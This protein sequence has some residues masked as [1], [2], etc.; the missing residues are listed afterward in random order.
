M[1][2]DRAPTLFARV[3]RALYP[4]APARYV[5]EQMGS[6]DDRLLRRLKSGANPVHPRVWEA[7]EG[8]ICGR[9]EELTDLLDQIREFSTR[10]TLAIPDDFVGP[11]GRV[12][13]EADAKQVK[14]ALEGVTWIKSL[15]A[16]VSG[17]VDFS[18]PTDLPEN[19]TPEVWGNRVEA[20]ADRVRFGP[21]LS[22]MPEGT[23]AVRMEMTKYLLVRTTIVETDGT[24]QG[25]KLQEEP[26]YNVWLT[27]ADAGGKWVD[28][29]MLLHDVP[30]EEVVEFVRTKIREGL[31]SVTAYSARFE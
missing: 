28:M 5:I 12:E 25:I 3:I 26:S 11:T 31:P 29:A 30:F 13:A 23:E 24:P 6:G 21:Q 17:F 2:T 14:Q 18:R 4:G 7:L 27:R 22:A 19:D 1:T 20:E 8:E 15:P 9:L 16:N 10:Q